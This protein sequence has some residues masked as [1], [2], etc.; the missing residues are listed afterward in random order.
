GLRRINAAIVAM[1]VLAGVAL[2]PVWRSTGPTGVPN[3]VLTFAPQGI[4]KAIRPIDPMECPPGAVPA[5]HVWNPQVWGSWLEFAAPCNAYATDS[6]IEL[7]SA[8]T[9]R[10]V[11]TVQNA[12]SGWQQ[13]LSRYGVRLVVTDHATDAALEAA[14]AASRDWS[15]EW[16]DDDGSIWNLRPAP[17]G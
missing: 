14:L 7:F 4:A 12:A 10:D 15:E 3:G 13:V 2:L 8:A 9:W 11:D 6:R 1:L 16:R 17:G 5:T